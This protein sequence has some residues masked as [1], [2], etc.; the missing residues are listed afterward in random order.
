MSIPFYDFPAS[1]ILIIYALCIAVAK[2]V[3]FRV[4]KIFRFAFEQRACN[5][6]KGLNK[7]TKKLNKRLE[8]I[9]QDL[10]NL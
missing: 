6:E 5:K 1:T 3:F 10:K 7:G 4:S 8:K 9:E 2:A